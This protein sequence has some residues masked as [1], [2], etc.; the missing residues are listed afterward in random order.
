VTL[1]PGD[2]LICEITNDDIEFSEVIFGDGF[3]S[4]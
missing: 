2:D 3:E 1:N 4:N